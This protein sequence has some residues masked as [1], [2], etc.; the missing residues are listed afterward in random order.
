[1]PIGVNFKYPLSSISVIIKPISSK[2]PPIK[3][4]LL[5]DF[6]SF[7]PKI[8]PRL[9]SIIESEFGSKYSLMSSLTSISKPDTPFASVNAFNI[10]NCLSIMY[11]QINYVYDYFNTNKKI[12]IHFKCGL[13][14]D[15][16]YLKH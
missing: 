13:E 2:C 15:I 1:P 11:L 16:I 9:S 8:P 12:H 14:K 3:I 5:P 7:L 6:D 4:V 10:S